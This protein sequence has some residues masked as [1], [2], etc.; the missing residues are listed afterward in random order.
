M[1]IKSNNDWSNTI[2]SR[3]LL[4]CKNFLSQV[5]F[6]HASKINIVVRIH[7]LRSLTF[8]LKHHGLIRKMMNKRISNVLSWDHDRLMKVS[9]W[10]PGSSRKSPLDHALDTRITSL[11]ADL[12]K[13]EKKS[14]CI[15]GDMWLCEAKA[16]NVYLFAT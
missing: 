12:E 7:R 15:Y 5:L 6:L 13:S 11:C 1:R 2:P 16:S 9:L 10:L 14:F 8:F 3:R 4:F